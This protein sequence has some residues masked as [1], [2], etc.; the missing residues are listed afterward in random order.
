MSNSL[1][2]HGQQHDKLPCPSLSPRVCLNSCPLSWWCHSSHLNLCCPFSSC[3]QS[4]PVPRSFHIRWPKYWSFS[5]CINSSNEYSKL[6]SFR[7]D[8]F[9]LLDVQG[10]LKSLLD[11]W[12][13]H[14]LKASIL[15]PLA[16]FMVQLSHP[17]HDYGKAIALTIPGI[18]GLPS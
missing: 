17:V 4:F 6:I 14:N 1:W 7:I 8:W 3:L 5:F 2:P 10:T 16:F 18:Q 15:W 11:S 13:H 12:E 9:D